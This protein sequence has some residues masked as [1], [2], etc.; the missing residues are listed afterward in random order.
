MDTS[1]SFPQVYK[2]FQS[3]LE[4]NKLIGSSVCNDSSQSSKYDFLFLSCGDWDLGNMFPSACKNYGLPVPE[5]MRQWIN[6]KEIFSN[7]YGTKRKRGM[8][9]MLEVQL[10]VTESN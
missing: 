9:D 1:I 8:K 4:D 6:V 2:E 7:M 5:Y 10:N 3:W